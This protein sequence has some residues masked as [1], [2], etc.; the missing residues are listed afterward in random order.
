MA[1]NSSATGTV[2]GGR[3]FEEI[4][5]QLSQTLL[6]TKKPTDFITTLIYC[7]PILAPIRVCLEAKI[8]LRLSEVRHGTL[9]AADLAGGLGDGAKDNTE[10]NRDFIVRM[11]RAVCAVGLIDETA[12]FTYQANELTL[13]LADPGF[14]AGF[15]LIFDNVMGPRSTMAEMVDF[16]ASNGWIASGTATNGPWQR[17][18]GTAGE[19]TFDSWVKDDPKQLERLSSL[20]QRMQ[21]DRP[22]WTEWFPEN[23]LFRNGSATFVDIGGGLG[24][25]VTALAAKFPDKDIRLIVQDLESVIQDGENSQSKVEGGLHKRI[26]FTVHDFFKQQPVHGAGIYYMHKIMHDWPDQDCV[27]I[28]SHIRDAMDQNS[29]IFI[30]DVILPNKGCSLL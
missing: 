29:R 24:H 19:S 30:N 11:L 4:K 2:S 27:Q 5:Q 18:R 8:F 16:H 10:A 7:I 21:K 26:S 23:A 22:H 17:A 12:A 1:S 6:S 25:D 15:L 13:T 20:M 3:K 9:T 28:L 14:A